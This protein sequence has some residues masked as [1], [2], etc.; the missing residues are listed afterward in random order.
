MFVLS[1][2]YSTVRLG[3]ALGKLMPIILQYTTEADEDDELREI[4]LQ[5][6]ESFVVRCS[7]DIEP[8]LKR[9]MDIALEYL[10]YDPN[11]A[12]DDE[13]DE[14]EDMED[15]DEDDEYDDIA[16]VYR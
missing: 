1:S 14:D 13:D 6:L 11:Y 8:Y 7:S 16:Y 9:I 5:S 3:D 15:E 12:A 2:R 4:C 10:R